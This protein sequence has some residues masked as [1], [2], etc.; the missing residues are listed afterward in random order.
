MELSRSGYEEEE[1]RGSALGSRRIPDV[2]GVMVQEE[3][4]GEEEGQ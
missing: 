1:I 2:F 4:R 3:K